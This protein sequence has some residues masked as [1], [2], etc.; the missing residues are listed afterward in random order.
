MVAK[1]SN[2]DVSQRGV[3]REYLDIENQYLKHT[4]DELKRDPFESVEKLKAIQPKYQPP[5]TKKMVALL[6]LR[7][8]EREEKERKYQQKVKE[9]EEREARRMMVA[10][11][12]VNLL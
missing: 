4:K 6:D 10:L 12:K 2:D 3:T 1:N 7:K 8:K 11:V 5:T 9:Q